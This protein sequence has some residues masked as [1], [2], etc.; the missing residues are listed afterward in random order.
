MIF[1][2]P[3]LRRTQNS[4]TSPGNDKQLWDW[5]LINFNPALRITLTFS[6]RTNF[7]HD[8]LMKLQYPNTKQW[9][10]SP[11]NFFDPKCSKIFN[12]LLFMCLCVHPLVCVCTVC[13]QILMN[14]IYLSSTYYL[15]IIFYLFTY[16]IND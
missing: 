3:M 10:V 5:F 13:M 11:V 2:F 16:A 8:L 1:K 9:Q 15:S 6:I 14:L 4:C 12:L 7:K